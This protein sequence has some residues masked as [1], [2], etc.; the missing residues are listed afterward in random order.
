MHHTPARQDHRQ[1]CEKRFAS[2]RT[3]LLYDK[4][5]IASSC[6][7]HFTIHTTHGL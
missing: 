7:I 5:A 2:Y 4:L 1:R 6:F 3:C